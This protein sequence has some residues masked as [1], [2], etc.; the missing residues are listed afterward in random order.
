MKEERDNLELILKKTLSVIPAPELKADFVPSVIERIKK[1]EKVRVSSKW[2][3][4]IQAAIYW[5]IVL[6]LSLGL[7]SGVEANRIY[8]L[9]VFFITPFVFLGYLL[10]LRVLRLRGLI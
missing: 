7:F 1:E 4:L 10:S 6:V 9:M 5:V 3:A 2:R 8:L